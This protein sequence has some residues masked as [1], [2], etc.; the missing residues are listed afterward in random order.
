[1]V[2]DDT[3][4]REYISRHLE[5]LGYKTSQAVNG[6]EAMKIVGEG[7][8][9]L[10]VSDV[11]MPVMDGIAFLKL[12]RSNVCTHHIPVII[13]SSRNDIADRIEGWDNGADGYL[14][15]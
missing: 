4:L 3:E 13:L 6:Q 9:D 1:I 5:E 8:V 10:V 14:G 12:M 2:D 7:N 11:K 15:K